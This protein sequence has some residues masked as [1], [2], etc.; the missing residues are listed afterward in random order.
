M[1][2]PNWIDQT[3]F[4]VRD[5]R[6]DGTTL[7]ARPALNFK[8][9]GVTAVDNPTTNSIDVTIGPIAP[10]PGSQTL[11]D[12]VLA[13]DSTGIDLLVAITAIDGVT[14]P[15]DGRFALMGQTPGTDNGLY[16]KGPGGLAVRAD[17][18]DV[19]GDFAPGKSFFV[20]GGNSSAK[21]GTFTLATTG[22]ITLGSSSLR[23]V[24]TQPLM[25]VR[26]IGAVGDGV[27]NDFGALQAAYTAQ[28][29][30]Q[31]S[32]GA[33]R[34]ST[35]GSIGAAASATH[36][37]ARGAKIHVDNG[38]TLTM[39]GVPQ[40]ERDQQ[41]FELVG[42]GKVLLPDVPHVHPGWFG[43]KGNA[44]FL[45]T[46]SKWYT[47][48]SHTTLAT[49][50]S[51]AWRQMHDAFAPRAAAALQ[52]YVHLTYNHLLLT[53][54]SPTGV[55]SV[56]PFTTVKSNT[57]YQ[58]DGGALRLGNGLQ[59]LDYAIFYDD[60]GVTNVDFFYLKFH[61]NSD[62]TTSPSVGGHTTA[63]SQRNPMIC[64][65]GAVNSNVRVED[66]FF[67]KHAG[68]VPLVISDFVSAGGNGLARNVHVDRN[69]FKEIGGVST[70]F[71]H[72]TVY[73]QA[74]GATLNGNIFYN[75]PATNAH[76]KDF[77]AC[78][79][80][81]GRNIAV[82]GNTF[83]NVPACGLFC[84]FLGIYSGGLS[85]V[86]NTLD[87]VPVG[88]ALCQAVGH[89]LS[90]VSVVGNTG[91]MT[92]CSAGQLEGFV[93][94][95]GLN[96]GD[97]GHDSILVDDN[98][99]RFVH[100][101]RYA[102][103]QPIALSFDVSIRGMVVSNNH[104]EGWTGG[105]C[106]ISP[107]AGT[108]PNNRGVVP[109][110]VLTTDLKIWDVHFRDNNFRNC[111]VG[112]AAGAQAD[113]VVHLVASSGTGAIRR[114][115]AHGNVI[116]SVE[117][118]MLLSNATNATP[119]VCTTCDE[120]TGA[121][122]DHGLV[123]GQQVTVG[124]VQGNAAANCIGY[125]KVT[126]QTAHSFALYS[127]V[128][129]T[130][131][132]AGSG[133]YVAGTGNVTAPA[134]AAAARGF[135]VTGD[136]DDVHVDEGANLFFNVTTPVELA[137]S[138]S[139]IYAGARKLV[140]DD[141]TN[142]QGVLSFDS[143]TFSGAITGSFRTS[144]VYAL[145]NNQQIWGIDHLGTTVYPLLA[146]DVNDVVRIASTARVVGVGPL[147]TITNAVAK[148]LVLCKGGSFRRENNAQSAA[149]LLLDSDATDYARSGF[150]VNVSGWKAYAAGS[151]VAQA[152]SAG[153]SL[154]SASQVISIGGVDI[155]DRNVN[156]GRLG[157]NG[158]T[159][160]WELYAL[161]SKVADFT[162]TDL[163]VI[164]GGTVRVKVDASALYL[165][166]GAGLGSGVGVVTIANA[167]TPPTGT[168][169][170]GGLV[171]ETLGSLVHVGSS[172]TTTTLAPS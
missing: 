42:T 127:D 99:I 46:D 112:P 108:N 64:L 143:S 91:T 154:P 75:D 90:G 149:L 76:S 92:N 138:G 83:K 161:G 171:Y 71:D 93:Q 98:A 133:A 158:T 23:F 28:N 67:E 8:G 131:P 45:H 65:I 40:A 69:S 139:R 57:T 169:S 81:Q 31:Y 19:S 147:A 124:G 20:Q 26:V 50:D 2:L 1:E 82:N 135:H 16:V 137:V 88:L 111:G 148:D 136:G 114:V 157:F 34:V 118:T 5:V 10:L 102:D 121:A 164:Y 109:H 156:K 128:G 152:D 66:C 30:L 141:G 62:D 105:A 77:G 168:P 87:F 97:L 126:G 145:A 17:D 39:R 6:A 80:I 142:S 151:L 110:D 72:I 44:N 119:I 84:S 12:P 170:G 129:L 37:F 54:Q 68:E 4:G 18:A 56:S 11:W 24:R 155:L 32:V 146:I 94:T 79:Q 95:A 74:D 13:A 144:K 122:L 117:R 120:I 43:A 53:P 21:G 73:L 41:I 104:F 140:L 132:V 130:T 25:D 7:A 89:P 55:L 86:G 29:D 85:F 163:S 27:T 150:D 51:A 125:A 172:G 123:D 167:G 162:S 134:A 166:G 103:A 78:F 115:T 165:F 96:G 22:T 59:T 113:A 3:L 14:I 60:A 61:C 15:D 159:T 58:G 100:D 160:G 48:S 107:V 101:A 35:T 52:T 63:S 47:D 70:L 153:L 106:V 33:Y 38:V 36:R 49:D 116:S 9:Q